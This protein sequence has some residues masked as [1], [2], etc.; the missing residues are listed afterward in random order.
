MKH[1]HFG[2]GNLLRYAVVK[3]WAILLRSLC[4]K[5]GD[6]KLKLCTLHIDRE[7]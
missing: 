4:A 7:I 6:A 2:R 5:L 3:L 1:D